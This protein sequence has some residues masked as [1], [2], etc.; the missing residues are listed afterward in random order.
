MNTIS[1]IKILFWL[2]LFF[3]IFC[4]AKNSFA[5][6][7][8]V[9]DTISACN[10]NG[11]SGWSGT[12]SDSNDGTSKSTAL[13]TIKAGVNK[14]STS[15][16][17]IVGNGIYTGDNNKIGYYANYSQVP[18]GT[19]SAYTTVQADVDGGVTIDGTTGT[20]NVDA[21]A[22][23]G[24]APV[25]NNGFSP[26]VAPNPE[27][28]ITFRGFIVKG[29][30][31]EVS[32]A[33][34]IKV[35]NCGVVDPWDGN[36]GNFGVAFSQYVLL[37]GCY[38]WGGGRMKMIFFHSPNSIMRNCVARQDY[39]NVTSN[40]GPM[41]V[42]DV[43]SSPDAEVQNCI[44]IDGDDSTKWL[45]FNEDEGSFA[46]ATTSSSTFSGPVNFT[47]CI[48]LNNKH[49][50]AESDW[51]TYD[52]NVHITNSIGWNHDV[53]NPSSG[54]SALTW[55]YGSMDIEQS[56]FGDIDKA[57]S[58]VAY[59]AGYLSGNGT[60]NVTFK[61]NI[62]YNFNSTDGYLFGL[63]TLSSTV[64]TAYN[65][66]YG[67]GSTYVLPGSSMSNPTNTIITNPVSGT[68]LKYL[69]RL[70]SG[71]SLLTAGQ[72]GARVGADI[73]YQYGKSGTLWG[74][75]GYNL[76]QDGTNGQATVKLW[77]FPNEN[78]IKTQMAAYTNHSVNGAR[79]FAA[80]G[81]DQWGQPITLTRYIWQ[82]LGN[83][84]PSDIYGTSSDTTIPS[85]PT[86]ISV[87]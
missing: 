85:A 51:N 24:N 18:A 36:N 26:D 17:L 49:K 32:A 13:K 21:V 66:I 71:C 29:T 22:L 8:Y 87:N 25:D 2:I 48:S 62:M 65:N 45:G 50:F 81:N 73:E 7:Y 69:P 42:F 4:F 77:P 40:P 12:P 52:P 6:T 1:K 82:Y 14:M 57:N 10:A 19:S 11:G 5:A 53:Q 47:N 35:I 15:D 38:A 64:T 58:T 23:N 78:L 80:A 60:A 20:T 56:T 34:H 75:T 79:G 84:I 27:Q 76:P 33:N 63:G 41:S 59:F 72:S 30:P 55:A 67:S 37:E 61:N 43:Y 39:L 70:E 83:Q 31:L 3:G 16:T 44:A 86:G 74:D 28:Y 68:C 46:A 54:A 9:C